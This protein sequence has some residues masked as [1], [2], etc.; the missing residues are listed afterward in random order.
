MAPLRGGLGILWFTSHLLLSK[1]STGLGR[2]QGDSRS[3]ELILE[4][5]GIEMEGPYPWG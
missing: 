2:M 4:A 5:R 1:M 3:R